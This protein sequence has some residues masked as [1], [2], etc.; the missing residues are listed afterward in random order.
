MLAAKHDADFYDKKR[1]LM[2]AGNH[3]WWT[4]IKQKGTKINW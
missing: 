3:R 2:L 1:K 4:D